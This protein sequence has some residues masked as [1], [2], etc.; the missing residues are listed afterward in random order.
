[1]MTPYLETREPLCHESMCASAESAIFNHMT[2]SL[3][4]PS[5][6]LAPLVLPILRPCCQQIE[7]IP[8][9]IKPPRSLHTK[10]SWPK[11]GGSPTS[12]QPMSKAPN[13]VVPVS[14]CPSPTPDSSGVL[15]GFA[16]YIGSLGFISY[17]FLSSFEIRLRRLCSPFPA[18]PIRFRPHHR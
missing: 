18:F 7:P 17:V 9:I 5:T 6:C 2:P 10:S 13:T 12:Y 14:H 15:E 3:N 16:L 4:P 8:Q 11:T 1:M